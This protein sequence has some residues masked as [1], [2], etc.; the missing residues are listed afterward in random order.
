MHRYGK[1]MPKNGYRSLVIPDSLYRQI[2]QH[3]EDSEG[4]Y[5]SISEVVRKA[6]WNFLSNNTTH[7]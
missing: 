2:K 4:R 6:V 1:A 3:V 7:V 5:V